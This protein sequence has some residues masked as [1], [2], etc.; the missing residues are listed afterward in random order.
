MVP[1]ADEAL[2][3]RARRKRRGLERVSN[4]E[5]CNGPP[6][7]ATVPM[8]TN[9]G[10]TGLETTDVKPLPQVLAWL[11]AVIGGP[12]PATTTRRDKVHPPGMLTS[13]QPLKTSSYVGWH[14]F[15]PPRQ[16]HAGRMPP[17]EQRR[18]VLKLY[19]L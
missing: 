13:F 14:K 7:R 1:A 6:G 3:S 5:N 17:L 4:R 2:A 8:R 18:A 15:T 10:V 19:P 12:P 9:R 11:A 16:Q